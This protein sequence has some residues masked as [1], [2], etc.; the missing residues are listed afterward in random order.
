MKIYIFQGENCGIY[1]CVVY[2]SR[3]KAI[4]ENSGYEW[5]LCSH[6]AIGFRRGFI[7]YIV[8]KQVIE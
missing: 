3:E 7:V 8:E 6:G 1:D 5:K 4:E 2:N